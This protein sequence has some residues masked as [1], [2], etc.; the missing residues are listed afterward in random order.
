MQT[1]ASSRPASIKDMV[2]QTELVSQLKTII[3]GSFMRGVK[4][5][6]ML[7]GGSA[8]HGKTTLAGIVAAE[9]GTPL[10][11]ISGPMLKRQQDLVGIMVRLEHMSIVFVDEIHRVPVAVQESLYEAMEDQRISIL[12]GSGKDTAATT[13]PLV[14]FVLI[15]AT[16]KP[17]A[18]S[19]PMRQRFGW[20]GCVKPYT[21]EELGLI[22]QRHWDR[23][24]VSYGPTEPLEVA[25]RCKG[26]PRRALSLADRVLDWAAA[27]GEYTIREGVA[28]QALRAFGLDANGFDETDWAILI[29]L[30]SRYAG[31]TVGLMALAQSLDLDAETL[32]E[33][34]EPALVRADLIQRTSTGRMAKPEAYRLVR[35]HLA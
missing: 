21:V 23:K 11:T 29:A 15:G 10:V 20:F 6:H 1:Q 25:Q 16:T 13:L 18:L 24:G 22:V 14:P 27:N 2:G 19:E 34:H 30:C 17:G 26:V 12:L 4:P 35:E 8:G 5:P 33:Q 31:R 32:A 28:D 7:L 3:R 9:L